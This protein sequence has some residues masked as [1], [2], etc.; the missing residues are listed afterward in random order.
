MPSGRQ[1][2][3]ALSSRIEQ[4]RRIWSRC[5]CIDSSGSIERE[6]FF[7]CASTAVWKLSEV[8]FTSAL[9]EKSERLSGHMLSSARDSSMSSAIMRFKRSTCLRVLSVHSSL[10]RVISMTPTLAEMMPRGVFNSCE[11]SVINRRCFLI[12]SANG[13]MT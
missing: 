10:P 4:R 1:Y 3:T 7:P 2:L 11:T 13:F 12:L 6:S 8:S 9:T 5:P